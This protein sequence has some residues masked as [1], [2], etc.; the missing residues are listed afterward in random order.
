M[1]GKTFK[2]TLTS[3]NLFPEFIPKIEVVVRRR[4]SK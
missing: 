2:L 3:S 1:A 4:S